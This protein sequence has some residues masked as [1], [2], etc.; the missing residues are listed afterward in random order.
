MSTIKTLEQALIVSTEPSTPKSIRDEAEKFIANVTKSGVAV[1]LLV[2]IL[3]N[4]TVKA[5]EIRHLATVL[6]RKTLHEYLRAAHNAAKIP[7]IQK[8]ALQSVI[9]DPSKNVRR[10]LAHCVAQIAL[11]VCGNQEKAWPELNQTINTAV[12]HS[13]ALF[14]ELGMYILSRVTWDMEEAFSKELK[15]AYSMCVKCCG[16][17]DAKVQIAGV[18]ALVNLVEA[19]KREQT[20]ALIPQTIKILNQVVQTAVEAGREETVDQ[21]LVCLVEITEGV[22]DTFKPYVGS[23]VKLGLGVA[24][25]PKMRDSENTE[26]Q[27][28]VL[29][30]NLIVAYKAQVRKSGSVSHIINT[31][32]QCLVNDENFG[33]EEMGGSTHHSA[34]MVIRQLTM[35]L[36]SKY[37]FEPICAAAA[38]CLQ[39]QMTR[40]QCVGLE[41]LGV[42]SEGCNESLGA[43]V[44]KMLSIVVKAAQQP[45]V[46]LVRHGLLCLGNWC[47]NMPLVMANHHS[48]LIPLAQKYL[49]ST[50]DKVQIT[51]V[52]ILE[53]LSESLAD[54]PE[55]VTSEQMTTYSAS[56]LAYVSK[57]MCNP[58]E[59][60][61][62]RG[63]ALLSAI[64]L[65]C[66]AS[67]VPHVPKTMEL[68]LKFMSPDYKDTIL[69]SRAIECAGQVAAAV[70]A[71]AI[72]PCVRKLWDGL[73]LAL[74][75]YPDDPNMRE[76]V[77]TCFSNLAI[78]MKE[79][80][81]PIVPGIIK[82]TLEDLASKDLIQE[83]FEKKIMQASAP[84]SG[85]DEE[86]NEDSAKDS[87]LTRTLDAVEEKRA[88]AVHVIGSLATHC[89]S[90]FHSFLAPCLQQIMKTD[91]NYP[92]IV[93]TRASV[94][95]VAS[96]ALAYCD[97]AQVPEELPKPPAP[98]FQ[99]TSQLL[100][101]VQEVNRE[102]LEIATVFEDVDAVSRALEGSFELLS[103]I[104]AALYSPDEEKR[105]PTV[106]DMMAT[107]NTLLR[108]KAFCQG[109]LTELSDEVEAEES[110]EVSKMVID[111]VTDLLGEL[112]RQFGPRLQPLFDKVFPSLLRWSA[113]SRAITD[114]C[115]AIGALADI[116]D[117]MKEGS[118]NYTEKC[119]SIT[120]SMLRSGECPPKVMRN[121]IYALG[122]AVYWAA[123]A[124]LVGKV[125]PILVTITP[126]LKLTTG[127]H[128]AL[129]D[130]ASGCLARIIVCVCVCVCVCTV[131]CMYGSM[132][133]CIYG[134]MY[135]W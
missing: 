109:G 5:E 41:M 130:N 95:T 8:W 82:V 117:G 29:V 1:E 97:Y 64:A 67:F 92:A 105:M 84:G 106:S 121:C 65:A 35:Q 91:L 110:A 9:R 75:Q 57:L 58:N 14:R 19:Q 104:G 108:E 72:S 26:S 101:V 21:C 69:K 52:Y 20:S 114:R 18:S 113:E 77:Y 71:D 88:A 43:A 127:T 22:Y 39:A 54:N 47:E 30:N 24:V 34:M 66:K 134:S 31:C 17:S 56:I 37:C 81:A 53:C 11:F 125:M 16:D 107:L 62:E 78:S 135:V 33:D 102:L 63:L 80:L 86:D 36:S 45:N 128:L 87:G 126:S 74:R 79:K 98:P 51:A 119:M 76:M 38:K 25:H 73:Q 129:R 27:A 15:W 131:V 94:T 40:V 48:L 115:T 49:L 116:M 132:V 2:N 120:M 83:T 122:V 10:S 133:V 100:A 32:T 99:P 42:L 6:L 60:Q 111:V 96:L 118:V 70:G 3:N 4:A 124:T 68:L 46:M 13:N 12:N 28:F 55:L 50:V 44:P 89:G 103:R 85:L 59:S 7:N 123:P 93:V 112:A 61:R 90:S 23:L